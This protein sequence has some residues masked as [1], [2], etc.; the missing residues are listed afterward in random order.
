MRLNQYIAH[1][2]KYSRREADKLIIEGRVNIQRSKATL[3]S[4]L[5]ENQNVYI[6]GKKITPQENYTCIVYHKP[7]GEI[8]SKRDERGRRV[9]YDT[10]ES[11]F[12]HFVSVGRL[13]F[14]S[15]GVLILTDNKV[16][17]KTLM[18]SALPRTYILKLSGALTSEVIEAMQNGLKCDDA[19]AGGHEKSKIIAMEFAPFE[20]YEVIKSDK[21]YTKLKVS[22]TEGKNRELRRFFAHFHCEVL[23]LKRVSYGFVHL[24]ALPCGKSRFFTKDEYKALRDFMKKTSS[25]SD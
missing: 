17:A 9:I 4:V 24:N 14:A 10:L 8:V 15:E 12:R 2:T 16:I 18:E 3:Q 11:K 13:D 5:L 22:I 25:L 21:K 19:R 6:D 23:D 7:K 1:H 20:S